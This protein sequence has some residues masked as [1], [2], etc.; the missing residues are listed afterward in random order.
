MGSDELRGSHFEGENYAN[1]QRLG[2]DTLVT[3]DLFRRRNGTH[4][5]RVSLRSVMKPEIISR[6]ECDMDKYTSERDFLRE[7]GVACGALAERQNTQYGDGHDPSDCVKAGV[8]AASE[9]LHRQ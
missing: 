3:V 6:V 5:M 8:Q 1:N 7:V 2:R 4:F 9:V